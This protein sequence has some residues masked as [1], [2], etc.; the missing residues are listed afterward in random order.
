MGLTVTVESRV[1]K[2]A[3][4]I[5]VGSGEANIGVNVGGGAEVLRD[6]IG[7]AFNFRTLTGSGGVSVSQVGDTVNVDTA[8]TAGDVTGPASATDGVMAVFDGA[9]GKQI[10]E[11][12][13]D[14]NAAGQSIINVG[15]VDGRDVSVDGDTLDGHVADLANPHA[16]DIDNL[17]PGLLS[18]LNTAITDAVLDDS[19]S[20]R[21]PLAHAASHAQSGTDEIDAADLGSGAAGANNSLMSDGIGGSF[22][23]MAVPGSH[24][25]SHQHGGADE[26][27]T[28]TPAA[29]AIPKAD[30]AG[31]LANGWVSQAAVT[32]HEA[33]IDHNAL[34]NYALAEHRTIND[35]GLSTTDLWSASKI[36]SELS[37]IIDGIDIKDGVDTTTTDLGNI[38]LAGE[39]TLNGLLTSG[40]RVLVTEQTI[41]ADNGIYVSAAGAWTRATDADQDPE[42]TNG[43]VV[44]V[45]NSGSTKYRFKYLLVTPDPITVGVTGQTWE[46]HRDIDFGTTAGTATEGNDSRVPGQ[47][48]NDALQGTDGTPSNANRYVTDTDPRNTNART[49]T[50]HASTHENGGGDEIS[51]AGLSGVL[52]DAQT[53]TTHASTHLPAG[54]DPLTTG[55]ASGLDSST[56]NA[57]GTTNALARQDHTHEISET[58]TVST[59]APDDSAADGSAAGFARKDHVHANAAAAPAQGIGASNAEGVAT[60]FSRSDHD[61]TIRESGGQDLA[62]GAVADGQTLVRSGTTIAGGAA[63]TSFGQDYQ[64]AQNDADTTTTS[65]TYV[66][67]L[68]LTTPALTGTYRVM[69]YA[70]VE[71]VDKIGQYRL[72]NTTDAATLG[73]ESDLRV[74]TNDMAWHAYGDVVF[75][76]AAKTFQIQFKDG[77]GGETQT[78]RQRRIEL[79]RVS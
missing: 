69:A 47:D 46:E 22:W 9:T 34:T 41:P 39:Q 38:S 57:E 79:W 33:A 6:K 10:K 62:M 20:A 25:P 18:E 66:S 3:L 60:S 61:H 44:H 11:P 26:V 74:K 65:A 71:N 14:I 64:T 78:I 8:L 36:D 63:P 73:V 75:T 16:T 27:A 13:A 21:T 70:M 37:A 76:G 7:E 30:G 55:L 29:N 19:G 28:A 17:G 68:S 58:G 23:G 40:S 32:Q 50:V 51:V 72:Q 42:V 5:P 2:L 31:V 43:N 54:A 53:P 12:I 52:A 59:I 1:L 15:T 48:E 45:I 67:A 35:A 24:A 77:S 56:V 49:P 4:P